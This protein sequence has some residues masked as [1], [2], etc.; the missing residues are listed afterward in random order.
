MNK[1]EALVGILGNTVKLER[2][3][4]V[5]GGTS[6]VPDKRVVALAVDHISAVPHAFEPE[7]LVVAAV[8]VMAHQPLARSSVA[9][10]NVNGSPVRYTYKSVV[11]ADL[12]Q[13][14]PLIGHAMGF[15]E[16]DGFT[17]AA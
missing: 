5:P 4:I 10:R 16:M 17:V 11:V 13:L 6:Y 7:K 15:P 2:R 12:L 9:V 8:I 3:S 14:P 1:T